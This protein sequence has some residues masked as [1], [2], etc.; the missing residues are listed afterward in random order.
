M[1]DGFLSQCDA[2]VATQT[3]TS[4]SPSVT[5]LRVTGV[6]T[7]VRIVRSSASASV[8]R[9]TGSSTAAAS[10]I[11][12]ATIGMAANVRGIGMGSRW[13]FLV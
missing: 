4:A 9:Q 8:A 3:V 10:P 11:Q 7:S 1:F 5:G 12:T 13:M 6:C 2:F